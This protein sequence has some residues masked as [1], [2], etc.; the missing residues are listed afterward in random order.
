MSVRSL[1]RAGLVALALM[2][3]TGPAVGGLAEEQMLVLANKVRAQAGCGPLR[4]DPRL[5]AAAEGHAKAMAVQNFF[6]HDG[7]NG[8]TPARRIKAQGYRYRV[9][10]ENIAAGNASPER[11]MDQ[12]IHS[13]GHLRNLLN[14]RYSDT[15]IALVIQADDQPLPGQRYALKSYWVQVFAH[16]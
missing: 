5:T 13:A 6:S 4:S 9:M 16:P 14:C 8:S 7:K 12:W 15:G 1:L 11:T 10:A 3:V 2:A